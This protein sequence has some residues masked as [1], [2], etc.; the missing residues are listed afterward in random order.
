VALFDTWVDVLST[1]STWQHGS[2]QVKEFWTSE[3]V[4]NLTALGQTCTSQTWHDYDDSF[5]FAVR[6]RWDSLEQSE[7]WESLRTK[8]DDGLERPSEEYLD[9]LNDR[10]LK[11]KDVPI[12]TP[13]LSSAALKQWEGWGGALDQVSAFYWRTNRA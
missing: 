10:I 13:A 5:R 8:Y 6:D 11:V 9:S 2:V 1:L 7:E 12:M 3:L 4:N